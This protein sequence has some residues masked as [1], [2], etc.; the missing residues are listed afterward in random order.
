MTEND[1]IRV[2]YR[3]LR[4]WV[5]AVRPKKCPVCWRVGQIQL[6]H[7]IYAYKT[8]EIRKEP[9]L[10]LKNATFLCFPCHKIGDAIRKVHEDK[11]ATHRIE[12]ERIKAISQGA[13][14]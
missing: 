13:N 10:V 4:V 6:H 8:A 9:R 12:L 2:K 5:V 7:W 3:K 1:K 11:D 14:S